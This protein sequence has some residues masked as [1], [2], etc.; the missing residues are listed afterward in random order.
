M[1]L[2]PVRFALRTLRLRV[3]EQ[4][5]NSTRC[6]SQGENRCGWWL[7][8]QQEAVKLSIFAISAIQLEVSGVRALLLVECKAF[9]S[10]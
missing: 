2:S 4:R 6:R 3:R 7:I 10:G 9:F 8:C 1:L 5:Q